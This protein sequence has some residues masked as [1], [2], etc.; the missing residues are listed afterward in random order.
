MANDQLAVNNAVKKSSTNGSNLRTHLVTSLSGHNLSAASKKNEIVQEGGLNPF[1]DLFQEEDKR[2]K[3][4]IDFKERNKQ[5]RDIL[6]RKIAYVINRNGLANR[7]CEALD[8]RELRDF[9]VENAVYF[10]TDDGVAKD[11]HLASTSVSLGRWKSGLEGIRSDDRR[12]SSLGVE[13][14]AFSAMMRF[15]G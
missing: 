6:H 3:T 11:M 7:L 8:V 9:L 15:L 4:E 14:I 13:P 2:A 12:F 5:V 10:R 1:V